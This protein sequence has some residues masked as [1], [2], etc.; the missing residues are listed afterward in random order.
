VASLGAMADCL[1]ASQ[2]RARLAGGVVVEGGQGGGIESF[3]EDGYR[4]KVHESVDL[5]RYL[6]KAQEF[7]GR[8]EYGDAIKVLQDVLDGRATEEAR[9]SKDAQVKVLESADQVMFAR[10]GRLCVPVTEF[11]HQ[12]LAKMPESAV[13]LY[14]SRHDAEAR[15]LYE[16][17][18]A[19]RDLDGLEAVVRRFLVSSSGDDALDAAGDLL[20]D[21]GRYRRAIARW[22][23]LIDSYPSDSDR[24]IEYLLVKIAFCYARLGEGH[25]VGEALLRLEQ[26]IPN[27]AVRLAGEL[28]SIAQLRSHAWFS[29]RS[30]APVSL[31]P[32]KEPGD[33]PAQPNFQANWIYRFEEKEPYRAPKKVNDNMYMEGGSMLLPKGSHQPGASVLLLG[34]Q[35]MV[36]EHDRT[37]SFEFL[38]GRLLKYTEG[39]ATPPQGS[40]KMYSVRNP[41]FDFAGMRVHHDGVRFYVT[42]DNKGPQGGQTGISFKNVIT[43]YELATGK[44]VWTTRDQAQEFKSTVF[45]APPTPCEGRL[46]VP[47]LR[48]EGYVV[49]CLESE[50]GKLLWRVPVHS[51]G[52]PYVRPPGSPMVVADGLAF[53]LSNAGAVAAIDVAKGGVQ[54]IRKY[55]RLDPHGKPPSRSRTNQGRRFNYGVPQEVVLDGFAPAVPLVIEGR[56]IIAP[57]DGKNLLALDAAT[58]DLLWMIPKE[59]VERG[60]VSKFEYLVGSNGE[61]LFLAGDALQCVQV[62]SGIRVWERP[63]SEREFRG[64]GVVTREWVFLPTEGGVMRYSI[65]N[66]SEPVRL[67]FEYPPGIEPIATP[68]NLDIQG[69]HMVVAAGGAVGVF[70]DLATWTQRMEQS[71]GARPGALADLLLRGGKGGAALELYRQLLAETGPG[72]QHDEVLRR[73]VQCAC[74]ESLR[75]AQGGDRKGALAILDQAT[76]AVGTGLRVR[77]R[78]SELLLQRIAVFKALGDVEGAHLARENLY[79]FLDGQ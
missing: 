16:K 33:I 46:L 76:A 59:S 60:P 56:L 45:I 77:D 62:R 49:L 8:E 42:E 39:L 22:E 30:A 48:E 35:L 65:D 25:K 72:E 21:M 12:L 69:E 38:T 19:A 79:E 31:L 55:E 43:A 2:V 10:D 18:L 40:S 78:R 41:H 14:R 50:T 11:C 1:T 5:D 26:R 36:K 53:F 24:P 66:Q 27:A 54:W 17:A 58:G 63:L 74:E 3:G 7:L 68:Y 32:G 23:T 37:L 71:A 44:K 51:A 61:H 57:S 13:Q 6:L 4:V 67:A 70:S 28:H 29:S 20:M 75:L 64:R 47:A 34:D 73:I 52:T 15:R 9:T